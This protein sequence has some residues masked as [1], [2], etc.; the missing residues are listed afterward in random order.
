M[1]KLAVELMIEA[2]GNFL[3]LEKIVGVNIDNLVDFVLMSTTC[4]HG[5][6]FM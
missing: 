2:G 3:V 1:L 6:I 4:L 5:D